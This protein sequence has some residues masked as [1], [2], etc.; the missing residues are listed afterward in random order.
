M[1]QQQPEA[2]M[3]NALDISVDAAKGLT[4]LI[5]GKL[6]GILDEVYEVHQLII[7]AP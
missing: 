1:D 5:K 4:K 7:G 2:G 3:S 6:E